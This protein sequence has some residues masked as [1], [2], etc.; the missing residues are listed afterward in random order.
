[1]ADAGLKV[2]SNSGIVQIDSQYRNMHLISK[3]DCPHSY[4]RTTGATAIASKYEPKR[5]DSIIAFG[6]DPWYAD[7]DPLLDS[8]VTA[9]RDYNG[10]INFGDRLTQPYFKYYGRYAYDYRMSTAE[11]PGNV[12]LNTYPTTSKLVSV[13]R[14]S[15]G[16]VFNYES[17][18]HK[19]TMPTESDNINL[20]IYEFAFVD[21]ADSLSKSGMQ[22]FNA[23]GQLVFDSNY[24]P[25]RV[26]K[27]FESAPIYNGAGHRIPPDI[28]EL[29]KINDGV[30]RKY[31]LAPLD[32]VFRFYN[33]YVGGYYNTDDYV[34][35][36]GR[37]ATDAF[38][39]QRTRILHFPEKVNANLE[40]YGGSYLYTGMNTVNYLLLDVTGY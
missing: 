18:L 25:M 10:D 2:I 21:L 1:M 36:S 20:S 38:Q 4:N 23:K 7:V 27:F 33:E 34:M 13:S 17:V 6:L 9:P 8:Q 37:S 12:A 22:V 24:K 3:V 31:A 39:F 30:K 11:K 40:A 14:P 35:S 16:P 5:A 28:W 29:P 19:A 26:V 15:S 32:T